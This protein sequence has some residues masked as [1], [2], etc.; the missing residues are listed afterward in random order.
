MSEKTVSM[1]ENLSP[2]SLC[3]LTQTNLA[4]GDY[5]HSRPH[6]ILTSRLCSK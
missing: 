4:M 6:S 3:S 1:E 2:E 5:A